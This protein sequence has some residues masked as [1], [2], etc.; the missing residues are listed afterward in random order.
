MTQNVIQRPTG[1]TLLVIINIINVLY[2]LLF[3]FYGTPAIF[4]GFEIFGIS[5]LIYNLFLTV[6]LAYLAYGFFNLIKTAWSIGIV[7]YWYTLA[8][9]LMSNE[10][11]GLLTIPMSI[12]MIV[13]LVYLYS[14]KEYFNKTTLIEENY[15]NLGA[16]KKPTGIILLVFYLFFG[17]II[18]LFYHVFVDNSTTFYMDIG[19]ISGKIIEFINIIS[20]FFL[21][22]YLIYGFIKLS[23]AAWFV[24]M[25]F[26]SFLVVY[27]LIINIHIFQSIGLQLSMILHIGLNHIPIIVILTYIYS[28]KEYFKN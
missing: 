25:I 22:V 1:I 14:K 21:P 15:V 20:T 27:L 7:W 16:V 11:F 8:N 4:Y 19:P 18:S 13:V 5:A 6:I 28:K 10:Y 12:T 2:S 9:I 17:L 24:G 3:I 23:K 26:Y